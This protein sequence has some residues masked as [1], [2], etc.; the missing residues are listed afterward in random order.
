MLPKVFIGGRTFSEL[1]TP[2]IISRIVDGERPVRPWGAQ[3]LGLTD[4][5]WDTAVRCWCKDPAQRPAMTEVL[6]LLREP[7]LSSLEADLSDFLQAYKTWDEDVQ[8]E[9]A[10]EFADRLDEVCRSERCDIRSLHHGS[11]FLRTHIFMS[12][13]AKNI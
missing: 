4:S 13:S 8:G 2:V 11:R 10:Q 1:T 3:K 5:M 6:E 7:L 9:E 12:T